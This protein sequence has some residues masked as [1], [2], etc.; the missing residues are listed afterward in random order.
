MVIN[1]RDMNAEVIGVKNLRGQ[2]KTLFLMGFDI[3]LRHSYGGDIHCHTSVLTCEDKIMLLA[4]SAVTSRS[5]IKPGGN[6]RVA[7][8]P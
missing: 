1:I 7:R 6:L 4:S 5:E 2:Y 3:N 8:P